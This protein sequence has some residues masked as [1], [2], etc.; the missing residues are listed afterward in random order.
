MKNNNPNS[1]LEASALRDCAE[2]R[3]PTPSP[4]MAPSLTEARIPELLHEQDVLR[5]EL[6]LQNIALLEMS[7][8]LEGNLER[9]VD[10]YDFAPV[11]YFTLTDNGTIEN[12]NFA[13]ALLFGQERSRLI[14]RRFGVFIPMDDLPTFNAF[15][16]TLLTDTPAICEIHMKGVSHRY[17]RLKGARQ[18]S[19][20]GWRYYIVAID[21]TEH[22]QREDAIWESNEILSL[23][24]QHSPIF[25]FIKTVT[26]TE[27]RVLKASQNF[28][29]IDSIPYSKLVGKSMGNLFP[30]ELAAKMA[31]D[32]WAVVLSGQVLKQDVIFN[33]RTYSTIRFPINQGDKNLVA[34]YAIDITDSVRIQDQSN[35]ENRHLEQ[36][37]VERTATLELTCDMLKQETKIRHDQEEQLNQAQKLNVIG[38]F[39][40]GIAHDFNN[41]LT[42]IRGNLDLLYN[43][44]TEQANT[45]QRLILEDALS[46]TQQSIE[47]TSA[48]LVFSRLQPLQM[49][50]TRMNRLMQD[51]ERRLRQTFGP[52]ITLKINIDSQ[53]PDILTDSG[54]LQAALLNLA[55]NARDAMPQGGTF[56][57]HVALVNL[58]NEDEIRI[59]LAPGRYMVMTVTD[60]G[61]GMDQATLA[62]ACEPFFTTKQIGEGTGL[63]LSRVYGFA[64]QSQ[65]GITFRS[66]LGRGTCVRLFLPAT[67]SDHQSL[68]P[69]V[70]IVTVVE[71]M[72]ILVVEDE[73]RVR[74][75]AGRYLHNLGHSVLEATNAEEAIEILETEP[76]IQILFSDIIMPGTVDGQD[77][78]NWTRI[79]RP[80][81]KCLLTTGYNKSHG[82]G[83]TTGGTH[84]Q[85]SILYKPYSRD[86]LADYI[87]SAF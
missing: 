22:K 10:F 61:I 7:V 65:G 32:D 68:A 19:K 73:S 41:L 15:L 40:D 54:Q 71:S 52:A 2:A 77:L 13:G 70:W 35:Q 62:R 49:K 42:I 6:E 9:Y 3:L 21:I 16:D 29:E 47:L 38:E 60:T 5:I 53:F 79:H 83:V 4:P 25:A 66:E 86:Q 57:I 24:V 64:T 59:N 63:G 26:P 51:L 46:A 75:L 37:I 33:D 58:A 72:V 78:A 27:S 87:A 44:A 82:V 17:L 85:F 39:T 23:F 56:T 36:L 50:P 80:T 1:S 28:H 55:F 67:I 48:L 74:R 11:G 84:P 43:T 8:R 34:G 45:D 30:A 20:A 14:D 81:V 69:E 12:V 31:A 76:D 18:F